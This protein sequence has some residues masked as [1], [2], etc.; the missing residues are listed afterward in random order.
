MHWY[1]KLRSLWYALRYRKLD[2]T[3]ATVPSTPK[4][5][6]IWG[7]EIAAVWLRRH[8]WRIIGRRV[9][10]HRRDEIDLIALKRDII[11]FIEVKTRSSEYFARP[12][13]AVNAAKR[14]ALSRA[15][16]SFI[17]KHRDPQMIYRFDIIEVVSHPDDTPPTIR[18]LENAIAIR[19]NN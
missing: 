19:R 10:P 14:R 9:R 5:L 6:G 13:S 7:E 18:H 17:H 4:E 2:T 3:T 16:R 1:Y 15:A 8:G 12:A 11:I